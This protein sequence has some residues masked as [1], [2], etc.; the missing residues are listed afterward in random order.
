MTN[1]GPLTTTYTATGADCQSTFWAANN[2]NA[3]I[4]YGQ[5]A[6]AECVPS[7]FKPFEG[8]HYS[9]GVCPSGYTYACEAGVGTSTTQATCCPT[10]YECRSGVDRDTDPFA[11]ASTFTSNTYLTVEYYKFTSETGGTGTAVSTST[12]SALVTEYIASSLGYNV[13]AYGPI[14]RRSAGDPEWSTGASVG[15]AP[16]GTG[17][18]LGTTAAS[19]TTPGSAAAATT[20]SQSGGGGGGL[21]VGASAGIGVGVGVG[22]VIFIGSVAAAYV[23]GKRRRES[24]EKAGAL[25]DGDGDGGGDR[26]APAYYRDGVP[27]PG[28]AAELNSGWKP[29]ELP[30]HGSQAQAAVEVDGRGY[31]SELPEASP[32]VELPDH[33][34]SG[35]DGHARP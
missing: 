32:L 5:P 30:H 28:Q 1:L 21:S 29:A 11:C 7:K 31:R 23:I 16:S 22:C 18:L 6:T 20:T 4:Q 25:G 27:A 15:A 24:R 9:P 3:W 33:A 14:V 19:V 34:A 12:S 8:Y 26:G 10:G 35:Y 13:E 2:D 17:Q